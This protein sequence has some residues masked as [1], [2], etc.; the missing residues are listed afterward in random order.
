VL[1]VDSAIP[2]ASLEEIRTL[3]QAADVRAVDLTE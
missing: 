2:A 3:I 1:S